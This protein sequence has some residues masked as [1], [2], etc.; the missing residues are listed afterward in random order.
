[1][2]RLHVLQMC[3]TQIITVHSHDPRESAVIAS[4]FFTKTSQLTANDL[5]GKM[6]SNR[7]WVEAFGLE[8]IPNIA[9]VHALAQSRQLI[10]TLDD[11]HRA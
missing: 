5:A 8:A 10:C 11:V 4:C 3:N 1:M 9:Q 6:I 7:A 2:P